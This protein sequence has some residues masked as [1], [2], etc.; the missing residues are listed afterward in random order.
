MMGLPRNRNRGGVATYRIRIVGA[1]GEEW[2]QRA[3]GM[4]LSVHRSEHEETYS[5]LFGEL[6][7][8]PALMGVLNVLYDHGAHLLTV[9]RIEADG[10]RV[11]PLTTE[12][13][14]NGQR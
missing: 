11:I 4:S 10:S 6:A 2:S 1:L 12:T 3:Q 5:E 8:E 7:D 13:R 9:E 14:K